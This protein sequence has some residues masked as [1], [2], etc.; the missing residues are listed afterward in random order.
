MYPDKN[1][2][3]TIKIARN[4][5]ITIRNTLRISA[6]PKGYG[7]VSKRVS[8]EIGFSDLEEEELFCEVVVSP[9]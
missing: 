2:K 9:I 6:I 8:A 4:G 1:R 3:I 7:E 5:M